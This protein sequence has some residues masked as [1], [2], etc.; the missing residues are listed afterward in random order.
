MGG[1]IAM[2]LR[3]IKTSSDF[4]DFFFFRKKR[5]K[6]KNEEKPHNVIACPRLSGDVIVWRV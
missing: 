4:Q 1:V 5:R 2:S 6:K 3:M